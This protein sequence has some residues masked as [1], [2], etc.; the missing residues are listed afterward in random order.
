VC[1]GPDR[2][3]VPEMLGEG[4]GIVVAPGD[5]TALASVLRHVA[6]VP[7]E[8][9]SMQRRAA[10]WAQQFTLERFGVA[11]RDEL[12]RFWS[13]AADSLRVSAVHA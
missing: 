8:Y 3:I 7:H 2:G 13:A 5:A 10:A 12:L 11:L 4:R 9:E 1:I 6:E